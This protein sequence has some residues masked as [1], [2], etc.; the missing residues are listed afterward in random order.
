MSRRPVIAVVGTGFMAQTHLSAYSRLQCAQIKYVVGRRPDAAAVAAAAVGAAGVVGLERVLDDPD[1]DIV[2]ITVP[3]PLHRDLAVAALQAG[4]HVIVEKPVALDLVQADEMIAAARQYGRGLLVAHVLR[5]WPVYESISEIVRSN[6]L[7]KALYA[8]AY[9]LAS[10]PRWAAWLADRKQTGGA[11]VDLGIHDVDFLNSLFGPPTSVQAWGTHS[12]DGIALQYVASIEYRGLVAFAEASMAMP[13]HYPFTSGIQV[14]FE[15]G[16]VEHHFR[17]GGASFEEGEGAD[18]SLITVSGRS[19]EPLVVG[20]HDPFEKQ[21]GH[22]V[23]TLSGKEDKPVVTAEDARLAL[24]VSD[25]INRSIREGQ[26][27]AV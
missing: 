8:R 11:A 17:A 2:D 24:A 15:G 23:D 10:P 22:F 19:P 4:K 3:T 26:R 5:F 9:R 7:G 21:L 12:E 14:H 27:I 25:S 18:T 20:N 1:V 6:R 13:D 16:L